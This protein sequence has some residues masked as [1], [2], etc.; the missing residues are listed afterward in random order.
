[1]AHAFKEYQDALTV[2]QQITTDAQ[3]STMALA[4][5]TFSD[6]VII[7]PQI[8][9]HALTGTMVLVLTQIFLD[10]PI[11]LPSIL[12][13]VQPKMMALASPKYL[14]APSVAPTTTTQRLLSTTAHALMPSQDAW[15]I[16]QLTSTPEQPKMMALVS[17][18][19]L[20]HLSQ[21]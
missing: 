10:A 21:S 6:A 16:Q 4:S 11:V 2:M 15:M 17:H 9:T 19:S 7:L 3:I 5:L 8:S 14:V 20:L 18:V 1:M 13:T 12:T